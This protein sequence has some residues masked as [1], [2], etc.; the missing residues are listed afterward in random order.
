MG[1][2]KLFKT[3]VQKVKRMHPLQYL[4][5]LSVVIIGVA[6]TFYLSDVFAESKERK[7]IKLHINTIYSELEHNLE[8]VNKL[9][10]FYND[11]LRLR[12]LLS[13]L[14]FD[15]EVVNMDSLNYY[16]HVAF[17]SVHF[18]Y[19]KG[20]YQ[21]LINSGLMKSISD[22]QLLLD[23]TDAYLQLELVK[24]AHEAHMV[25]KNQE[26]AKLY[27]N[28]DFKSTEDRLY[29]T[30]PNLTNLYNFHALNNGISGSINEAKEQIVATLAK[31]EVN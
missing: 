31:R 20:A 19:K 23:I 15:P 2:C 6:I 3:G 22:K 25:L 24:E 28:V 9:S 21:M 27:S 5:E 16:S 30:D 10:D 4:R 26:V 13:N 14:V 1:K 11:H 12:E 8:I 7:E 17:S 18:T 29:I